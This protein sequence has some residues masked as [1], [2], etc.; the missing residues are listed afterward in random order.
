MSLESVREADL[1]DPWWPRLVPV[2]RVK[3]VWVNQSLEPI[4]PFAAYY[5]QQRRS[6]RPL[7]ITAKE[8]RTPTF[9]EPQDPQAVGD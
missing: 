2:H 4:F 7:P 3:A 5:N 8:L 1:S 9:L 6:V